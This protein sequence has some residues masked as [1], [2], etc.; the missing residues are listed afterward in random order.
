MQTLPV[1]LCLSCEEEGKVGRQ[2]IRERHSSLI[3]FPALWRVRVR[4]CAV[5]GGGTL[6]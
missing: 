3:L 1:S 4:G 5:G 6:H 2:K